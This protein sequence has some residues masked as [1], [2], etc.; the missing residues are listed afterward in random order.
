[1]AVLREVITASSSAEILITMT[2]H[3]LILGRNL[4]PTERNSHRGGIATG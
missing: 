1:M 3:K 4:H 2:S